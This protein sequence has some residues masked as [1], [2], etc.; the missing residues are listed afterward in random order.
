FLPIVDVGSRGVPANDA[1][2][3]VVERGETTEEPAVLAVPSPEARFDLPR[4][5]A[6]ES[7][8]RGSP[9][10]LGVVRVH[11]SPHQDFAVR[12]PQVLDR[13]AEVICR[14][15]IGVEVRTVAR[16]DRDVMGN[17]IE[18]LSNVALRLL[19]VRVQAGIL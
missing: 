13:Q 16:Q 14:Y 6:G 2:S 11:E 19:Q 4:N 15:L 18:D 1:P 9:G 12:I 17:E 5:G 3:I 10:C 8:F 7:A